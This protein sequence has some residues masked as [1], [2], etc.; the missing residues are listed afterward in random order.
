VPVA[1]APQGLPETKVGTFSQ[2]LTT[3]RKRKLDRH[4]HEERLE[5]HFALDEKG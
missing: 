5:A 3:K 2:E 1:T 4:Q